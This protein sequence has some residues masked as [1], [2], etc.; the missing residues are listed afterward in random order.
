MRKAQH[1]YEVIHNLTSRIESLK[2]SIRTDRPSNREHAIMQETNAHFTRSHN[3]IR[4]SLHDSWNEMF[5]RFSKIYLNDV[6]AYLIN[7]DGKRERIIMF[8]FL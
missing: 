5:I 6:N 4:L 1:N 8:V 7:A 3:C 2:H